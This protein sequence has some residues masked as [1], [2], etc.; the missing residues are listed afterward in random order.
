MLTRKLNSP[1]PSTN[2]VNTVDVRNKAGD[3]T[4]KRVG[5]Y[6]VRFVITSWNKLKEK[7]NIVAESRKRES[8][9]CKKKASVE[10]LNYGLVITVWN[11]LKKKYNIVIESRKRE[12]INLKKS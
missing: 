10:I 12:S 2:T 11:K 4:N 3:N 5:H 9:N 6:Y 1:K 7:Y 8:F